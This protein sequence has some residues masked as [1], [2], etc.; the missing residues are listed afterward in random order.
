MVH[1]GSDGWQNVLDEPTLDSGLGFHVASLE[2]AQL[3]A[4]A[5]V[6][7][8]WKRQETAAWHGRDYELVI[9]PG[10]DSRAACE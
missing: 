7:F 10:V 2:A 6:E 3:P 1:W 4:N 5:H 9:S 8:T